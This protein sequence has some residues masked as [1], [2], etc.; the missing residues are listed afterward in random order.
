LVGVFRPV[1][2]IALLAMCHTQEH[3]PLGGTIAAEL[4]RDDDPRDIGQALQQLAKELLRRLLVPLALHED[5]EPVAVLI[6]CPPQIVPFAVDAEKD[7]IEVPLI[8]RSGAA[9]PS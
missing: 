4:I 6:D 5:V 3:L 1:V 8:T 2:E 9:M 7:F